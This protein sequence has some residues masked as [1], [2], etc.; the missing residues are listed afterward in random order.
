MI[1]EPG[2]DDAPQ[3]LVHDGLGLGCSPAPD[4]DP[5]PAERTHQ[6]GMVQGAGEARVTQN[7]ITGQLD[8]LHHQRQT[9]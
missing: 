6:V 9:Y 3:V 1:W 5:G 8:R 7:M 4:T 2:L